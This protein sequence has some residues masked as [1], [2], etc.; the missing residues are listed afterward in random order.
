LLLSR[1]AYAW[2]Q[3]K[4]AHQATTAVVLGIASA[5]GVTSLTDLHTHVSQLLR[6]ATVVQPLDQGA[7]VTAKLVTEGNPATFAPANCTVPACYVKVEAAPKKRVA[8]GVTFG[9]VT[10]AGTGIFG[11]ALQLLLGRS[12]TLR[13]RE[14]SVQIHNDMD[15]SGLE[16]SRVHYHYEDVV[17]VADKFI[18]PIFRNYYYPTNDGVDVQIE[19]IRLSAVQ[20]AG[21]QATSGQLAPVFM[22]TK[23]YDGEVR[24]DVDPGERAC[25]IVEQ[26][27]VGNFCCNK[28]RHQTRWKVT[29]DEDFFIWIASAAWAEVKITMTWSSDFQF[30][31]PPWVTWRRGDAGSERRVS[32]SHVFNQDAWTLR[33]RGVEP[34]DRWTFHWHVA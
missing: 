3:V 9:A 7:S 21:G 6:D 23:V 4:P 14:L 33:L 29:D 17:S 8:W 11:V 25:F 12:A 26:T 28:L 20:R 2:R 19:D 34:E 10:L 22:R 32:D 16:R 27:T 18:V 5:V 1:L 31:G 30:R 24:L 13:G 15:A